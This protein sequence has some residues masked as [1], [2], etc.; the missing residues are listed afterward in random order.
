[1]RLSF[2]QTTCNSIDLFDEEGSKIGCIYGPREGD[3][4]ITQHELELASEICDRYNIYER[5]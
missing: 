3:D 1:M 4:D 2:E 5:Y